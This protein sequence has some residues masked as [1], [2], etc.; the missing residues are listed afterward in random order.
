VELAEPLVDVLEL[1]GVRHAA[2]TRSRRGD[3]PD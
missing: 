1:D 2:V 3:R